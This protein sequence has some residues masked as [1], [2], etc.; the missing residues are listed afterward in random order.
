MASALVLVAVAG[1]A[2]AGPG[3]PSATGFA[4]QR[5]ETPSPSTAPTTAAAAP[6]ATPEPLGLG[7]DVVAE[8]VTTDLVMRTGPAVSE[9]SV[10]YPGRLAPGD[11]LFLVDGPVRADGYDWFLADPYDVATVPDKW[12]SFGW[13]AAADKNGEPW[14]EPIQPDC[15]T[16]ATF[17]SLAQLPSVLRERCFGGVTISLDGEVACPDLG[18]PIPTPSPDWLTW[19]A[20]ILSPPGSPSFDPIGPWP[21]DSLAIGFQPMAERPTGHLSLR[22]HVGDPRW[23]ECRLPIPTPEGDIYIQDLSDREM[24]L[25][26]RM[27]LMVDAASAAP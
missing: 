20:C 13:V 23:T 7:P 21:P 27:V 17:E 8:V 18:P 12:L 15:P 25:R 16:T 9:Q 26:C 6:T 2:A 5:A 4:T 19:K 22:L 11:R 1:C 14:I 24:Q 10:I 3:A